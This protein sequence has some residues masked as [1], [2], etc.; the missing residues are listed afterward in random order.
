VAFSGEGHA[1][2]HPA[3]DADAGPLSLVSP[4]STCLRTLLLTP[5]Q[6]HALPTRPYNHT[7]LAARRRTPMACPYTHG[8]VHVAA[9]KILTRRLTP[10]CSLLAVLLGI[11]YAP[12]AYEVAEYYSITERQVELLVNWPSILYMCEH[13]SL[14][15][16]LPRPHGA[17]RSTPDSTVVYTE[18][19]VIG[20]TIRAFC[21]YPKYH[22]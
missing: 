7:L 19:G 9:V 15:L 2:S 22:F 6:P 21:L 8:V 17:P 3:I 12:V 14:T 13:L 16:T 10:C 1:A 5:T 20:H 18:P 11:G 4:T